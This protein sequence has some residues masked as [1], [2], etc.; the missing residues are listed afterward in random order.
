MTTPRLRAATDPRDDDDG[1]D[2]VI[3]AVAVRNGHS[4]VV[5]RMMSQGKR[6]EGTHPTRT[7]VGRARHR[8]CLLAVGRWAV[9]V[10]VR[11]VVFFAC[12]MWANLDFGGWR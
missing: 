11:A 8:R 12:E 3:V 5:T 7:L 9:A 6:R 2:V 4:G 1:R 10:S